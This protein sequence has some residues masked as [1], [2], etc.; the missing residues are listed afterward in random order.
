MITE[1]DKVT[2]TAPQKEAQV[3]DKSVYQGSKSTL[4]MGC[5]HDSITSHI[6]S[7]YHQLGID[8]RSVA[9][10][11]GIGCS[12]KTPAY[13]MKTAHGFNTI[14]GR[15]A[16]IATGA[17]L[18]DANMKL[19]GISG[20]GD[21]ASIGLGGF[22]HMIRRNLPIV[23]IVENNGVYGLT[24]GQFS[25]TAD[26]NS[27]SKGGDSNVWS[28]MDICELA[29]TLGC[30]FVARSFS[31]DAKQ[32]VPLIMAAVRHA[33]TSV[34]DIISPC[35]TFANHEGSTRSY[36]HVRSTN[37]QLQA[38]GFISPQQEITVDFEE[39][40]KHEVELF[41]GSKLMLKKMHRHDHD[42]LSR[43]SA[44]EMI[45]AAR[46]SNE[47]VTGLFYLDPKQKSLGQKLALSKTSLRS[48]RE[49]D[50]RLSE[51]DFN[52]YLSKFA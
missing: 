23:Y 5:G 14:H 47:L 8:P 49:D 39:G 51:N 36:D 40:E 17:Y 27:L 19:I 7:A 37:K 52:Q 26:E 28:T 18:A 42:F 22:M 41:D 35:V 48:Y 10:I 9:K 12:S 45:E 24:K 25:A 46:K 16:P 31:G 6:I 29:L 44:I 32:L 15:L 13:F 4:C 11:S 2:P 1:N 43:F 30:G 33:G 34:I 3:F 50:L 38:L 21:T 20:D